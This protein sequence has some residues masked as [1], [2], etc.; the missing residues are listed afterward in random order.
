MPLITAPQSPTSSPIPQAAVATGG[1]P[2]RGLQRQ[3]AQATAVITEQVHSLRRHL[4]HCQ[5]AQRPWSVWR[6]H[7][8][9]LHALLAPRFVSTVALGALFILTAC[10]LA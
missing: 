7:A 10:A 8:E 5:A 2:L 4:G 1:P 6:M 9:D 3:T